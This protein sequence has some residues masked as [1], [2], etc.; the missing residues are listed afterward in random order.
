MDGSIFEHDRIL[1]GLF[2]VCM[3]SLKSHTGIIE[4]SNCNQISIQKGFYYDLDIITVEK[5]Y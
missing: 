4:G 5:I 2:R 1:G 3:G